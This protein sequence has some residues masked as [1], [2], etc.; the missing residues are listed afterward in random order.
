MSQE[1]DV[2]QLYFEWICDFVCKN[3]YRHRLLIWSKLLV[4]LFD[5]E[6]TYILDMDGNRAVDG[7]D[8]RHRFMDE[9][10]CYFPLTMKNRPCSILEMM[11]ALSIRCEDHIMDDPDIGDR[12]A[13]WFWSM[14]ESLGLS[15]M[16]N[17]MYDASYVDE[18]L[19]IFLNRE[20]QTNGRGGLFTIS[21]EEHDMTKV[22]IWY[23]MMCYLKEIID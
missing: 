23:Q 7:I 6:F 10:G 11:V 5:R 19:D 12:T 3:D 1:R 15:E 2:R 17:R 8:L 22:E 13:K 16:Q 21:H 18:I 9:T 14:I 4:T 20:Y